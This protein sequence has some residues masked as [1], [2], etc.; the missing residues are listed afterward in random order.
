M[1]E[2][3]EFEEYVALRSRPMIPHVTDPVSLELLAVSNALGGEVGELQ[4]I[5]K[6]LLRDGESLDLAHK[7][8]L[9]AGDVLHYLTRLINARGYSVKEVQ[10]AN[11]DKLETRLG[12]RSE[13]EHNVKK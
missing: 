4:N 10:D 11:I 2:L 12:F 7:F 8:L 3:T 9:E 5:V 6:K 13:K 1:T